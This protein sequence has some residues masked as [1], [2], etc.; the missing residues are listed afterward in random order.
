MKKIIFIQILTVA[1]SFAPCESYAIEAVDQFRMQRLKARSEAYVEEG[2]RDIE[3]G[4][5]MKAIRVLSE[6]M[7][8]GAGAEA[9]ELRARAYEAIG[10]K[11]LALKDL[12]R[13][14][15]SRPNEPSGYITRG[16]AATSM[17]YFERAIS[18]YD[19]AIEL[20]PFFFDAY[21]GRSVAFASIEK[22]ELS[23][24][25]LE[26][27]LKIDQNNPEALYN[28]GMICIL[29]GLPEAGKDFLN[30]VLAQ[31]ANPVDR[32]RLLAV[33]ADLPSNSEYEK[34]RGG[35]KGILADLAKAES[36]RLTKSDKVASK[37]TAQFNPA[38]QPKPTVITRSDRSKQ[39][40]ELLAKIGKEDFSGTSSGNYMGIDWRASFAFTGN[41][42]TGTLKI[43][44]PSGK[45]EVHHGRGTFSN[46]V[47]EASDN[48]GFRFSGRVTDDLKLIGTMTTSDGKSFAVDVPLDY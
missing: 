13:F 25:D 4:A 2:R 29:A 45:Q 30:R 5:Y 17:K 22:Y 34:K 33:L 40:R 14:I 31:E 18:D 39:A 11:D 43:V 35:L 8:K 38:D 37:I 19:R 12:N 3:R 46:G 16:D 7:S 41:T 28:M 9:Y 10:S 6:A 15:S 24:R 23:I 42:V 27:A 44:M 1:L 47:V 36:S 32:D 20:D 48:L 21:L 26:L